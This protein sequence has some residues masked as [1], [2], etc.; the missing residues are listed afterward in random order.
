MKKI[1]NKVLLLTVTFVALWGCSDPDNVV[2]DIFDGRTYG[3]VLR[4]KGIVNQNFNLTDLNS[5]FIIKLEEQDQEYGKL[6]SEMKVYVAYIDGKK[7]GGVDASKPEVLLSTV[8]KSSFTTSA[9]GLPIYEYS[10]SLGESTT[11][12]GLTTW[13][14]GD[15]FAFRFEL[16][17]TDGRVFS[18]SSTSGSL[19]GSYFASPYAYRVPV[20]CTPKPGDY[21]IKMHD[22][23]GDGWQTDDGNG[24]SG[25]KIKL[26]D[27]NGAESELEVGFCSPYGAAAGTFLGSANCTSPTF[28]YAN[29]NWLTVDATVTIPTGTELAVWEFPG[30]N[31]SEISFEVIA[32]DGTSLLTVATGTGTAGVLEVLNCL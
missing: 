10:A 8:S 6:L 31:W 23:Y 7:V 24:G 4:N 15:V 16:I 12:L 25:I 14:V 5:K 19:Q 26:T 11:A 2:Y 13:N 18:A 22:S 20:L 32:P 17:L 9:S 28:A 3:A 21:V 29:R 1:I 30:D 27:S